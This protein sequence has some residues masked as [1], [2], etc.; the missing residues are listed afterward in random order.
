MNKENQRLEFLGD[1]VIEM[2]ATDILF[3]RYPDEDEGMLTARRKHMVSTAA[4]CDA[5]KLPR[6]KVTADLVEAVIGAIYL[7]GGYAAAR[8]AFESLG[9][10]D[11]AEKGEW[12]DNPKGEL[13]SRTQAM[14]PPRQPVYTLLSTTGR[15]ND[16][17]FTIKVSVE[18]VGEAV[19]T[20]H[21][22]KAASAAAARALLG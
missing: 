15:S 17:T 10:T 11:Q 7:D 8:E 2:I 19:G 3:A 20:G 12:V 14:V 13:Q 18:G 21:S 16:P 5:V 4:L 9:L 6:E 22:K 1:A